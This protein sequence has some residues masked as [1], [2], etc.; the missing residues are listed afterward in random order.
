VAVYKQKRY[1][2]DGTLYESK[3]WSYKF[4]WNGR[5]IRKSTKQSN[6]RVAEQMESAAKT[7][8]AKGEIGLKDFKRAPTLAEFIDREFLPFVRTTK[9]MESNTLRDYE[10]CAVHLKT[11]KPL[12]RKL[13]N[14]IDHDTIQSFIKERQAYRQKRRK[15][16]PLEV[17]TINHDLRTLRH[18]LNCAVEWKR[19]TA[20]TKFKLL[21]GENHRERALSETE[22]RAYIDAATAHAQQLERA[23]AAALGGIRA[24]LRGQQPKQPDAFLLRDVALLIL[25]SALRPDECYQLT[26]ENIR[27]GAIW[28][29]KGKTK[30]AVRRI[31]VMS[32]RLKSALEMRLAKT[33]PG[34]WLFPA[35]TNSGHIEESTLKGPHEKAVSMS[36]VLPFEFY[37]LRHTCLTRWGEYMDPWKLHKYAGHSDMKTTLRYIHPH[38]E[39]MEDAMEKA[40]AAKEVRL[41]QGGHNSQHTEKT[42][43]APFAE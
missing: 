11:F 30:A 17:S 24:R 23:Y 38:D 26:P 39:S 27:D 29:F 16:K 22:D 40:R 9:G 21:P 1:L 37:I 2:P 25:D 6:K 7:A 34:A 8:L 12:A 41:A 42:P 33:A 14:E 19:V 18:A 31:P 28:I 36:G 10:G 13:L 15:D 35:E 3:N 20:V 32:E 43:E 5:E 4:E